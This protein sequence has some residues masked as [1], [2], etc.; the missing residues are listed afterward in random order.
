[1]STQPRQNGPRK[2]Y[3]VDRI[4]RTET[5]VLVYAENARDANRRVREGEGDEIDS[6][7]EFRGVGRV[8]RADSQDR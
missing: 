8:T 4:S 6:Y 5:T 1:M 3:Y 7:S 2:A